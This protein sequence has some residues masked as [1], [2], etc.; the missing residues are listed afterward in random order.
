MTIQ[1]SWLTVPLHC[2]SAL[3]KSSERFGYGIF[4]QGMDESDGSGTRGCDFFCCG[5]Q[6][7]C[8]SLP[9]QTWQTLCSAPSGDQAQGGATMSKNGVGRC[10]PSMAG[11]SKIESATHAVAFD[12]GDDRLG[13]ILKRIHQRLP[14]A[15]K[16]EGSSSGQETNL[17]EISTGREISL[18]RDDQ[19]QTFGGSQVLNFGGERSDF[20]AREAI[21][22]VAG[23]ERKKEN[24]VAASERESRISRE[25][26]AASFGQTGSSKLVVRTRKLRNVRGHHPAAGTPGSFTCSRINFTMLSMGVPG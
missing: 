6:F 7:E 2:E 3:L 26:R 17:V 1:K 23:D 21:H 4:C 20:F 9:D 19:W 15:G 12:C 22:T 13:I 8:S 14:E 11:K 5:E 24:G 25:L 10:D 18:A 16:V